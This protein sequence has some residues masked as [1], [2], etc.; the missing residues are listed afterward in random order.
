MSSVDPRLRDFISFCLARRGNVW[1]GIYDEMTQVAG[2]RSFRGMGYVE[3]HRLGL[4]LNTSQSTRIRNLV[5]QVSGT[6]RH[7]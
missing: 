5:K 6:E 3:L 1:P 7:C 4:P 2:R